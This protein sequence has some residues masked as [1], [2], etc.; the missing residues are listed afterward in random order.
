MC[1][2]RPHGLGF[3]FHT[4]TQPVGTGDTQIA[5]LTLYICMCPSG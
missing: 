5:D 2:A 3:T 4:G 1:V